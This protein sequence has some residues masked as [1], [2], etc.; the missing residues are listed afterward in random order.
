MNS[1]LRKNFTHTTGEEISDEDFDYFSSFFFTKSV[2]KKVILKEEGDCA[3]YVY[4]ILEGS[5]YSFYT[6]DNADRNAIQF[7]LEGYWITDHYSFFSREKSV[8]SVQTLEP[9][10]LLVINREHYDKLCKSSHLYEHFFRLLIQNAFVALQYRLALTTSE[11]AKHRYIAFAEDY[12]HFIQRIPQY[13]IAS[14]LGIKPQS[15]SRIR[16]ELARKK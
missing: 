5:A 8:Y 9:S 3:N 10:E 15:L 7:A 11:D 1:L 4:F 13:L 2:D 6:N 14:Y 12:P 16:Q